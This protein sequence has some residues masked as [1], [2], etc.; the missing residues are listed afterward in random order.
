MI[1]NEVWTTVDYNTIVYKETKIRSH[2]FI[3]FTHKPD[4]TFDK[5]KARLLGQ[6]NNKCNHKD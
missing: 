5:T 1:D 2:M 4:E 3:K 6:A